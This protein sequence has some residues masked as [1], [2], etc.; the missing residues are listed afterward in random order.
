MA[1][2]AH[3][4]IIQNVDKDSLIDAILNRHD[5]VDIMQMFRHSEDLAPREYMTMEELQVYLRCSRSH[6]LSLVKHGDRNKLFHVNKI[7]RRWLVD[8]LSYERWVTRG[9]KF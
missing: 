8:R 4:L 6:A 7:G 9:G 5:L 3:K 1:S 2:E